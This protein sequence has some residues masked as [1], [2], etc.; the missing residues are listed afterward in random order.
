RYGFFHAL[1]SDGL[2]YFAGSASGICA[3]LA[4]ALAC[5]AAGSG[6][7]G[8]AEHPA[9]HTIRTSTEIQRSDAGSLLFA[10]GMLSSH[11]CFERGLCLLG[12][13]IRL[14]LRRILARDHVSAKRL[15]SVRD[16]CRCVAIVPYEFGRLRE[17]QVENVVEYENLPIAIRA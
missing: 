14:I 15:H 12:Q 4:A 6:A 11:Q 5:C 16:G 10:K 17:R 13:M 7:F 8:E 3:I 9:S 2:S 1:I